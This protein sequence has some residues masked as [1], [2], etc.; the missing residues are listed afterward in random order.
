M[1]N[2]RRFEPSTDNDLISDI[3]SYV[4]EKQSEF[5]ENFYH[6]MLG[7]SHL[8]NTCPNTTG[9]TLLLILKRYFSTGIISYQHVGACVSNKYTEFVHGVDRMECLF[10]L[11]HIVSSAVS[12]DVFPAISK[13]QLIRQMLFFF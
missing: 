1:N 7:L 12:D 6:L 5:E 10:N 2:L 8:T 11:K 3:I 13:K 4:T 9:E